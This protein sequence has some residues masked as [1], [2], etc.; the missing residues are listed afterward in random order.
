MR[1]STERHYAKRSAFSKDASSKSCAD[2]VNQLLSGA[3]FNKSAWNTHLQKSYGI[4][5]RHANGVISD[6]KGRVGS[7]KECRTNPIKQVEGKVKSAKKW[8]KTAEKKLN[9]ARKFYGKKPRG[10]RDWRDSKTGCR[11]PLSCSLQ[12]RNTNWQNLRF[13]IHNKKRYIAHLERKIKTLKT[14][15]IHIKV[16]YN[17]CFVV[18][19][20]SETCGNQVCQWDGTYI[21]FRV[22]VC[23]ENRFGKSVSTRLGHFDRNVNRLPEHGS[24]TWHLYRKNGKWNTAVQ[25]TPAPVKRVSRHSDWGCIGIDLNPGS[26]G[27]AYVDDQG[28]LKHHGKIPLKTGLP[29]GKQ[30]AQIVDAVMQLVV[31]AERFE[32]PIVCEYL[33]FS[34]KK[35]TLRENGKKYARML[36]QWAYSKFLELLEAILSNRGIYL[37]KENPAYT[38]QIGLVKYLRMYGISSDVAAGIAIARRGMRLSERLPRSVTALIGVNPAKH[39]WSAWIQL[40]KATQT[41]AVITHRHDYYSAANCGLEVMGKSEGLTQALTKLKSTSN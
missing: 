30:Q 35:E 2:F 6:A 9:D 40:N 23:L 33:D 18:G 27:W 34:K 8:L 10:C 28:N 29:K 19:S 26:I 13:Q 22:P 31:L 14:T 39:V 11:Y 24:K 32:C 15:P 41:R 17:Q 1:P 38:S 12:H 5:K 25:F 20:R 37:M 7:A 4:N 21:K 3:K 16:P 36:S